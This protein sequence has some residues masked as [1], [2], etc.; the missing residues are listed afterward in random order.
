M[1]V[2][3]S[4]ELLDGLYIVKESDFSFTLQYVYIGLFSQCDESC[5]I[6]PMQWN[7]SQVTSLQKC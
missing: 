2:D 3:I 4:L 6:I 7:I 5:M 1:A